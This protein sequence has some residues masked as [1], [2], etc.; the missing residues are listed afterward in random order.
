MTDWPLLWVPFTLAAALAQVLR[1]AVQ[2]R[3]AT[4]IGTVGGTQVRFVYGLPVAI[5]FLGLFCFATGEG[6]TAIPSGALAWSAVGSVTQIVATALM[7]VVMQKRDFGVAYAYIKTEP[8]T[9]AI[10]GFA[11]IGDRLPLGGWLAVL[12]VT[13][14]VILASLR[15]GDGGAKLV[16]PKPLAVGVASG[17]L[18]GLTAI[19]FRASIAGVPEGSFMLRSLLMLVV[20]LGIQSSVLAG[21]FVLR[22]ASGF[23]GSLREW[24]LS[25]TG[26]ALGALASAGWFIAFSLTAAANVRTLALIEMPIVAIVSR[27]LSGRWLTAREWAGFVLITVGVALLMLSHA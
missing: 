16:E 10:L 17:A 8:V 22:D 6:L 19:C 4:R 18:F 23:F 11:L 26:G 2:S 20:S 5:L 27:K 7:L 13:F 24:R 14:G 3:L 1:N 9:V 12:I 25:V 21:W 15:P